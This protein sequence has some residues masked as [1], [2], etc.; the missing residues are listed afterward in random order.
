MMLPEGMMPPIALMQQNVLLVRGTPEAIDQFQEILAYFDQPAK[1][2]E[3]S[4]KFIEVETTQDKVFG[5]DWWVSNGSAEFFNLGFAPGEG[6]SVA[7]FVRGRFQAEL[8]T[9]LS[10]GR[11]QV[12]NEPRVTTQN[13]MP[14]EV[15]FST[16]IPYFYATTDYDRWGNRTVTYESESVSVNQSLYVT[17]RINA[18]DSVTLMLE[19]QIDDQVGTV[20]GPDG[21][22]LPIITSQTA[23]TQVRVADGDTI[24]IGGMIRR[25]EVQNIRKTPLLSEIPLIGS[26]FQS[27]TRSVRNTELLIFVTVNVIR[28]IPRQ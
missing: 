3:I 15:N 1:Q 8:R 6:I 27:R 5:I 4:T 9:L 19:P 28:D 21:T 10:E 14:A 22:I 20:V 24:V 25:N 17:P 13:N 7:R 11:A 23:Y 26:L 16:E 2:V 12:I 18:D